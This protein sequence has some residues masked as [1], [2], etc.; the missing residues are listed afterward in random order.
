MNTNSVPPLPKIVKAS[1]VEPCRT[2]NGAIR[3][4]LDARDTGGS[5]ALVEAHID[6]GQGAPCHTHT[7]ED[8]LFLVRS[9]RFEITV[10]RSTFELGPGGFLLAPRNIPH[11]FTNVGDEAG[12]FH[13]WMVG[14]GFEEIFRAEE[15]AI[16]ENR[17]PF[18]E[19]Q[20]MAQR[21]GVQ[22]GAP[23]EAPSGQSLQVR[24]QVLGARPEEAAILEQSRALAAAGETV[25]RF[26][27]RE[28]ETPPLC[29][30]ACAV[31]EEDA[32][33]LVAYGRYEFCIGDAR[34]LVEPGD[35]VFV[36]R[37]VAHSWR[38]LSAAPARMVAVLT[39]P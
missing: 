37:G 30:P 32:A 16:A 18:D 38:A 19:L 1:S 7:R 15:R 39:R 34:A 17:S 14:A 3:V 2:F 20:Q 36:P 10:A 8:E 9:G 22:M 11:A 6:A 29:G 4:L 21:L 5:L 28:I 33:F 26:E 12:S 25:G 24:P 31:R 13:C 23:S 35:V 27:A